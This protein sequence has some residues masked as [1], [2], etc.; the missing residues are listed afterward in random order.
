MS[1][2]PEDRYTANIRENSDISKILEDARADFSDAIKKA[3]DS[4]KYSLNPSQSAAEIIT[5]EA[6][7]AAKKIELVSGTQ[8]ASTPVQA[9]TQL[10]PQNLNMAAEEFPSFSFEPEQAPK[11]QEPREVSAVPDKLK[12]LMPNINPDKSPA[13]TRISTDIEE[14]QISIPDPISLNPALRIFPDEPILEPL[15]VCTVMTNNFGKDWISWEPET[16]DQSLKAKN[17][18]PKCM[19]GKF[20]EN[21]LYDM[22]FAIQLCYSHSGV[23]DFYTMFEKIIT[24]FN[25]IKVDMVTMQPVS[26]RNMVY[27]L[28]VVKLLRPDLVNDKLGPELA[29][30]VAAC[31]YQNG[32]LA[33]PGDLKEAQP[34]MA[35]LVSSDEYNGLA[36][37][38]WNAERRLYSMKDSEFDATLAKFEVS[39]TV[40]SIQTMKNVSVIHYVRNKFQNSTRQLQG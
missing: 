3:N 17:L 15:L 4:A 10:T 33:V 22:I 12:D 34:E 13:I 1:N 19:L 23:M 30:Y 14:E 31:C 2:N 7:T 5:P 26:P 39:E 38:I 40:S 21:V 32:F 37:A 20:Q 35:R 6:K 27:G 9:P 36:A 25:F 16:I 28:R 18:I 8:V 11:V 29:K 24:A